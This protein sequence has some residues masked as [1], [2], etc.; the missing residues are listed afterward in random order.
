L[1]DLIGDIDHKFLNDQAP[2]DAINPS[3][4]NI[5]KFLHDETAKQMRQMSQAPRIKSITV[6]E[7][8]ETSATY[9]P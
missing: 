2:F 7:T 1:R 6:W 8:D 5:A 9:I 4:E 3:A